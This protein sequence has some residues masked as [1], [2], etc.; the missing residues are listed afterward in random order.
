MFELVYEEM[1]RR[2]SGRKTA[3]VNNAI[4]IGL[5]QTSIG[6]E[7]LRTILLS[8]NVPAPSTKGMQKSSNTVC[9]TLN[10]PT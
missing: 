5:S 10:I 6:N 4:Q 2:G 7:G 9:L 3:C 1:Q 8:V